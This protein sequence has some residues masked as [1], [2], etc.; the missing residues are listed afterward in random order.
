MKDWEL[1]CQAVDELTFLNGREKVRTLQHLDGFEDYKRLTREKLSRLHDRVLRARFSP[2]DKLVQA[3]KTLERC[4][5]ERI[6]CLT[7]GEDDYPRILSHSSDFPFRLYYRGERL[8]RDFQ[9][10]AVVGTRVPSWEGEKE[11]FRMG[12]ELSLAECPVVSGLALGIDVEAHR[13]A[14][15]GHGRTVA[16]L[17]S[18]V[19]LITPGQN[20]DDALAILSTGGTILSE[21]PPGTPGASW[22]FPARN[23]IISGLSQAV[24]V[25][26]APPKSGAL[27]T[28]EYAL[29][30]GREVVITP[31]GMRT[32]GS[33]ALAEDGARIVKTAAELL[34]ELNTPYEG[35]EV[36]LKDPESREELIQLLREEL[37]GEVAVHGGSR[38]RIS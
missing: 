10:V 19:D 9:G 18:G 29:E 7:W 24:V 25:V 3:E 27:I 2:E 37:K 5:R 1:L 16:V 35:R 32:A 6:G 30:D 8:L 34:R 20:Y 14:L 13:G 36:E 4:A 17:G 23:R 33:A 22:R 28:V 15:A 12:L 11:A 26:Q 31:A 38:Y 21:Y